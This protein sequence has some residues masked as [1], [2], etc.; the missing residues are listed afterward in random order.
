MCLFFPPHHR[1]LTNPKKTFTELQ[2]KNSEF[3]ECLN[4]VEK[5]NSSVL[6]PYTKMFPFVVETGV[7]WIL[8]LASRV[9]VRH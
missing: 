1:R 8:A 7:K 3:Y 4:A 9:R 5:G 6:D 2:M